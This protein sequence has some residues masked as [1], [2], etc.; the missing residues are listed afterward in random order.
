MGRLSLARAWNVAARLGIV[1]RGVQRS[2]DHSRV[3]ILPELGHSP[4]S[5]PRDKKD[6]EHYQ[7]QKE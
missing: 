7:E 3:A 2:C 5:P 1:E 4:T 6:H